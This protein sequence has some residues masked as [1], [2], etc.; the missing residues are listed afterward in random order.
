MNENVKNI[1]EWIYCIVIALVLA[2]LFRY[3]IGTPT[4]VKQRS[5]YPTLKDGQRLIL[6]R[7]HR[8][9]KKAPEVGD[10]ITFEGPSKVYQSWE[11]DQSNP[12]AIYDKEPEGLFN[13]FVY[14]SL[15]LTKKSFIKRVIATEGQHVRIEG[16]KVYIN[17]KIL[18]EDYLG[19]DVVTEEKL[20]N[21]FVVPKGYIF[22]MGDNRTKSTDCREF[23]CIPLE[24]VEGIVIFRFWP[25]DVWGKVDEF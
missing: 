14:Y 22:A 25:L 18:E 6:N 5:M 13:R 19:D 8:I 9:T 17:G 24:K 12:V 4:I 2:L 11:V 21:N 20:F 16:N 23:G 3:F 1:L 15:E 10:I 7:T